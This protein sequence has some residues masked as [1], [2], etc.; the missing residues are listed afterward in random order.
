MSMSPRVLKT[1][2]LGFETLFLGSFLCVL[3]LAQDWYRNGLMAGGILSM[4]L[5]ASALPLAW[6]SFLLRRSR[7]SLAVIG[8]CT[9]LAV[10]VYLLCT[11]RLW[12]HEG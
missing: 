9:I 7:R 12:I 3:V 6:T 4:V 2:F 1:A 11:P 5:V 8:G 10:L